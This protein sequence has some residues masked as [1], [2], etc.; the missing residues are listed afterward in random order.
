MGQEFK[1]DTW[2]PIEGILSPA[3]TMLEELGVTRIYVLSKRGCL[4]TV[5]VSLAE[6]PWERAE[7]GYLDQGSLIQC[8]TTE[9]DNPRVLGCGVPLIAR[10]TN[11]KY[12]LDLLAVPR[13]Y[14]LQLRHF[15]DRLPEEVSKR[16]KEAE[17]GKRYYWSTH[18][19]FGLK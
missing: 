7:L 9:R 15:F 16:L 5:G 6:F 18:S 10:L 3:R 19:P 2:V 4:R 1:E 11:D 13:P 12:L 17:D 8:L 14:M